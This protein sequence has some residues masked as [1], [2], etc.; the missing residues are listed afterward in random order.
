MI[1]EGK[2][3]D[4][5]KN[6]LKFLTLLFILLVPSSYIAYADLTDDAFKVIEEGYL[7]ILN[8]EKVGGNVKVGIIMLNQA[9]DLIAKGGEDNLR[10]AI[11]LANGAK[12][13]ALSIEQNNRTEQIY[14][15]SRLLVFL[16]ISLVVMLLIKKYGNRVYYSL[17]ASTRGDWRI[18]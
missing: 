3:T 15:Y 18:E 4:K 10:N 9:S 16:I 8:A 1:D 2:Q 5:K 13:L 14:A 11:T 17:W 12:S 6:L 7:A